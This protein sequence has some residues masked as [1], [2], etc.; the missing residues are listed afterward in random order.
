MLLQDPLFG[1][2]RDGSCAPIWNCL[3]PSLST[4]R[5]I[6]LEDWNTPAEV[7]AGTWGAQGEAYL[8]ELSS[9]FWGLS[10]NP[11]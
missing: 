1:A 5:S 6:A 4:H 8:V 10:H 11:W 9:C 2:S 7:S 3:P